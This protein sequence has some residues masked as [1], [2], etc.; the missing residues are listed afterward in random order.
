MIYPRKVNSYDLIIF[1]SYDAH[2]KQIYIMVPDETTRGQR[3][4][5]VLTWQTDPRVVEP[6]GR[7]DPNQPGVHKTIP[8]T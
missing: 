2:K 5:M 6:G 1:Y 4:C 8:E 7:G 3:L